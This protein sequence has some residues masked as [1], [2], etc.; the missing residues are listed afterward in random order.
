MCRNRVLVPATIYGVSG[1]V[2]QFTPVTQGVEYIVGSFFDGKS[3]AEISEGVNAQFSEEGG[4][5]IVADITGT[6]ELRKLQVKWSRAPGGRVEDTDVCTFHFLKVVSGTPSNDWSSGTEYS[7]VE[8]AFNT[9]WGTL[10]DDYPSYIHLDQYRWYKDGPAFWHQIGGSGPFVPIGDNPS[11]RI[12]EV[13]TAGTGSVTNMLPPQVAWSVTEITS[14]RRH[15]GRFY[16]PAAGATRLDST[17][18]LSSVE[19]GGSLTASVTFYNACRAANAI[20]VVFSI[21][22][23]DRATAGGGELPA[24]GAVAYEVTSLQM[25]DICDVIRSRRWATGVTKTRTALT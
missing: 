25:D 22:K 20:P 9:Y 3:T 15:W 12:T 19:L 13:D 8:S 4:G 11:V 5:W 2:T 7:A 21:A 23:P 18:L 24:V 1:G 17:G 6:F 10:K 16:L 14:S